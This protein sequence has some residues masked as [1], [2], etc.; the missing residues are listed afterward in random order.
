MLTYLSITL[1]ILCSHS[2]PDLSCFHKYCAIRY[3]QNHISK[4][5][6]E[7]ND[8]N[9][10]FH[11]HVENYTLFVLEIQ[12]FL[13]HHQVEN[14]FPPIGHVIKILRSVVNSCSFSILTLYIKH[15]IW[16]FPQINLDTS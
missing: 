8:L 12:T 15:S 4:F 6:Y 1:N 10:F 5:P 3:S 14:L 13:K 9:L 11:L 7:I 2:F 16:I